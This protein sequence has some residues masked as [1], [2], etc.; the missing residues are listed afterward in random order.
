MLIINYAI[1]GILLKKIFFRKQKVSYIST[2]TFSILLFLDL[3]HYR[4]YSKSELERN[5]VS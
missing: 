3:L 5:F 4:T 2:E 1:F